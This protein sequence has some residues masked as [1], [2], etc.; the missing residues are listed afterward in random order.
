MQHTGCINGHT[1]PLP[2]WRHT[3]GHS[4]CCYKAMNGPK[5]ALV[6]VLTRYCVL[7][8]PVELHK[9]CRMALNTLSSSQG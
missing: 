2:T 6:T 3:S 5:L 7:G 8:M 1:A 9:Y 4:K